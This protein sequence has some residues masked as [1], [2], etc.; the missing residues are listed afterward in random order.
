MCVFCEIVKGNIPSYKVFENDNIIAFLDLEQI[1]PGHTL[2]VVKEH[3]ETFL[4]IKD[5]LIKKDIMNGLQEVASI[6]SKKLHASNFNI[7]NNTGSLAG[8]TVM[9]CHFHIIPR[10]EE[11][12]NDLPKSIEETYSILK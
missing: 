1:T 8:Q 10:Y 11:S 7:L 9:H 6:L 4:D 12:K 2:I 5:D 3:Y